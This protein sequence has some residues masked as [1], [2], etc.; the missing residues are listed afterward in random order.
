METVRVPFLKKSA[1]TSEPLV[2]SM[3]GARLGDS[4]V[5]AGASAQLALPL[6]ARVG[7]S[8]R[9]LVVGADAPALE[10]RATRD[11]ILVETALT[12]PADRTFDLAVVEAAGDWDGDA[13]RALRGVRPGGRIV[14]IAGALRTGLMSKLTSPPAAISADAI[15]ATLSTQGW[16]RVRDIGRRDGLTFVEAFAH[17]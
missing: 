7:L 3:T 11:G 4:V 8:G 2:L 5:F 1:T 9:C 14:V 13:A 10:A 15:V 16:Q 12:I 17:L 6:A